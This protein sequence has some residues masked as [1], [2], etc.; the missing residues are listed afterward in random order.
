LRSINH[1]HSFA[2]RQFIQYLIVLSMACKT[3]IIEIMIIDIKI[4]A[5]LPCH[6]VVVSR[7]ANG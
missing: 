6:Q 2:N 7:K 4:P 1:V 3:S 5:L